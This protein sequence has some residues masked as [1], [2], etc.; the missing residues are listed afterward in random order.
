MGRHLQMTFAEWC[1]KNNATLTPYQWTIVHNLSQ[2][3]V[4]FGLPRHLG[5]TTILKLW[6]EYQEELQSQNE[7]NKVLSF[8]SNNKK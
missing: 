7:T 8:Q 6:R 5:K 2:K 3:N 4:I 1:N